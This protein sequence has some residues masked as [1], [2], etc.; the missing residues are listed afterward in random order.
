MFSFEPKKE[1]AVIG[2]VGSGAREGRVTGTAADVEIS[3]VKEPSTTTVV[4]GATDGLGR[5]T[6]LLLAKRGFRVFA[7]GRNAEKRAR[8]E[9]EA[10]QRQLP[11]TVLEMDVTRDDSVERALDEIRTQAGPIYAVVNNAGISIVAVAEEL[12]L[13]HFRQVFETN[14][15]GAVRVTQ[16][17]LPEMRRAGR[18]RIINI[19]SIAGRVALPLFGAY[20]GSKF[21]LEGFSDALRLEVHPFGIYVSVLEPGFIPTSMQQ[22]AIELSGEYVAGAATSPYAR[23]YKGF[24]EG[25]KRRTQGVRATPEDCARVVLRAMTET[26]PRP[27]YT[28]TRGAAWMSFFR[29][30]LSDRAVDRRLLRAF[31]LE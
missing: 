29:R 11:L 26:P 9:A 21:A 5:A 25:W 6:A 23:V 22:T 8:L 10:R 2:S 28:V 15:F 7:C 4:T 14:F 3:P 20:S 27:R 24:V 12:R 17:V 19:S 13:E 1:A 16:R 18:G 30:W 31:R